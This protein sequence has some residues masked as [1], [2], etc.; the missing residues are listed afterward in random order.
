MSKANNE[1]NQW[2]G[3]YETDAIQRTEE[4]EEAKKKLSGRLSEAE[5]GVEAALAK[6][7]SLEKSKGRLQGEI[8]D[9]TLELERSNAAAVAKSM[10]PGMK[11]VTVAV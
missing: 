8:E 1:V 2:K 9:L 5:E 7:S 4:L 6:C 11:A 3:K 10:S